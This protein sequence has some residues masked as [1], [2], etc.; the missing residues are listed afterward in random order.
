MNGGS[1]F[2]RPPAFHS[3]VHWI[4]AASAVLRLRQSPDGRLL[5]RRLLDRPG[6]IVI[7]GRRPPAFLARWRVREA[8]DV[9]NPSGL[10]RGESRLPDGVSL[11]LLDLERWRYTP[12]AAQ[13][14]PVRATRCV[15]RRLRREGIGLLVAPGTDL[16]RGTR[17][18]RL[19]GRIAVRYLRSGLAPRLSLFASAYEI[20]SQGLEY[21]PLL[22]RR[23]VAA[24][25]RQIHAARPGLPVYAGLSTNPHGPRVRLGLLERDIRMTRGFVAGYWLNVPAPGGHCPRCRP[26]RTGLALALLDVETPLSGREGK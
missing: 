22:Y 1:S 21:H 8:Y 7:V 18:R 20:Q 13:R 25:V 9:T 23:T 14:H 24:L 11:V 15:S 26:P 10:C 16:L 3:L 5:A 12:R 19:G 17:W 6:T 4:L 2:A